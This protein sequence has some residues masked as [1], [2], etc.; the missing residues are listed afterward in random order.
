MRFDIL[1]GYACPQ[2]TD[3]YHKAKQLMELLEIPV[4]Y[5]DDSIDIH[6]LYDIFTNEDKMKRIV[7][8]LKNKAFW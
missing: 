1:D 7:S 3:K 4:A 2:D 8:I 6:S 5:Y